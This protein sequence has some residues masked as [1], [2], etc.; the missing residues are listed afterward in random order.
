MSLHQ[1]RRLKRL[2]GLAG[3]APTDPAIGRRS[4]RTLRTVCAVLTLAGATA[5]VVPA[6]P[7]AAAPRRA[8]VAISLTASPTDVTATG[9][10]TIVAVDVRNVGT[11]AASDLTLTLTLPPGA[12]P[13]GEGNSFAN[14]QCDYWTAPTWTCVHGPLAAGAAAESP[15]FDLYL[16]GGAHGE[17]VTVGAAVA[18]GSREL[19][20]TNNTDQVTLHYAEADLAAGLTAVPAEVIVGGTVTLALNVQNNGAGTTEAFQVDVHLPATMTPTAGWT[21]VVETAYLRARVD[22]GTAGETQTVTA[23][24]RPVIGEV[25][26]ANNTAQAN[27]TVVEPGTISGRLWTDTDRDGQ[28]DSEEHAT[29]SIR[30]LLFLPQAPADGDPTQITGVLNPDGT[31]TA[32]LKPGPYIV[33]LQIEAQY[34]DFTIPDVGDDATDSDI[35]TIQ[36]DSY[37]TTG[38]SAVIDVTPGRNTAVDAGLTDITS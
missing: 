22:S 15:R 16:P 9:G 33:Q 35:V 32:A 10:V 28:R 4:R 13:A 36:R 3:S 17:A 8:D 34:V 27:V 18:T 37:L 24:A 25:S 38:S 20:T 1:Q 11:D 26:T 12:G 29:T 5:A 2:G 7:A 19:S 30:T 23:T 21:Q 31:Y 6:G 14:W